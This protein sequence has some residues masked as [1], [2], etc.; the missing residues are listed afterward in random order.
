MFVKMLC[1]KIDHVN[2]N[3]ESSYRDRDDTASRRFLVRWRF[4][5]GGVGF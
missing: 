4:N 2:V 5:V 3:G 1:C